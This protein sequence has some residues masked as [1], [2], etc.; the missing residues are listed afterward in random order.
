MAKLAS[1]HLSVCFYLG[2]ARRDRTNGW[3]ASSVCEKRVS[4][5]K[6]SV[7]D[8]ENRNPKSMFFA[9]TGLCMCCIFTFVTFPSGSKCEQRAC[10]HKCAWKWVQCE[11]CN[12]W[13]H[14]VCVGISPKFASAVDFVC[15]GCN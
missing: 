12:R 14:C 5:E 2:S 9:S 3:S 8:Q 10:A 6:A 13:F 11:C 7:T 15:S 1:V 4:T